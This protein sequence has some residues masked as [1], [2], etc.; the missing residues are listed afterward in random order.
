MLRQNG[1]SLCPEWL[2]LVEKGVA[3]RAPGMMS[4]F[5]IKIIKRF[6]VFREYLFQS[7]Y[8]KPSGGTPAKLFLP[9]LKV[10]VLSSSCGL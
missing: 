8:S 7:I 1:S 2:A 6:Y 9:T 3:S 4:Q 10:Q 5:L